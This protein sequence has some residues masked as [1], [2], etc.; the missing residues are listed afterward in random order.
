MPPRKLRDVERARPSRLLITLSLLSILAIAVIACQKDTSQSGNGN[1]QSSVTQQAASPSP[2]P[3]PTPSPDMVPGDTIIVIRDGSVDITV[4]MNLCK[5]V[6]NPAHPDTS[7][8]CDNIEL[9]ALKIETTGE[10]PAT[11]KPSP[12]S[13]ITIDGGG[14]KSIVVKG[15]PNHVKID[16]KTADYPK[17]GGPGKHCGTNKVGTIT[18]DNPPFSKACDPSEKCVVRIGAK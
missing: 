17:C 13:R 8:R 1:S 15:N 3:S 4:D 14:A 2:S 12:T 5:D 11:P 10:P 9:D 18:M 16:F 7:Y 6:S